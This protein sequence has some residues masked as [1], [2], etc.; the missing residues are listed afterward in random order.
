MIVGAYTILLILVGVGFAPLYALLT[1]LTLP[2][3]YGLMKFVDSGVEG[4]PI[5]RA[6]RGK[7]RLHL[8]FGG[9]LALGY[10]IG[11]LVPLMS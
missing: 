8:L 9:A 10:I 2:H 3:A 7:E 6:V 4:H 11:V 1:L 5:S